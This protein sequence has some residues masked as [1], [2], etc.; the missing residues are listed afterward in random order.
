MP[1]SPFPAPLAG[2]VPDPC[3]ACALESRIPARTTR[4][5]AISSSRVVADKFIA[6]AHSLQPEVV[7][8]VQ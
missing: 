1:A 2:G 6:D 4:E 8:R 7:Q 5:S 3:A